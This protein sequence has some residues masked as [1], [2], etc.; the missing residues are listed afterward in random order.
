MGP[1]GVV[2]IDLIDDEPVEL[3]AVPDDSAVE[4]PASKGAY[5]AFGERIRHGGAPRCGEDLQTFGSEDLDEGV[6]DR[7]ARSRASAPASTSRWPH[8]SS[9]FRA[10]WLTHTPLG[11]SV[12]PAKYTVRVGVSM[13]NSR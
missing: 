9:R 4:E 10:A 5:P 11:W 8:W 12:T 13:K 3:A 7:L 1:V 2:V 6:D